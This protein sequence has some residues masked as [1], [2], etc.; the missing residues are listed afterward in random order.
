M[1]RSVVVA[2]SPARAF[3]LFTERMDAWWPFDGHSMFDAEAEKVTFEPRVGGAVLEWDRGGRNARWGTL[4]A[5]DPPH[6]FVMT[7]HPGRP[8]ATAQQLEV[9]F[10][11]QGNETLVQVEH[12]GWQALLERAAE[13]RSGYDGGWPKVLASFQAALAGGAR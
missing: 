13:A 1:R 4:L 10:T 12:R 8:E 7:W 3:A 2:C 9:T 5:W 11:A 6:R